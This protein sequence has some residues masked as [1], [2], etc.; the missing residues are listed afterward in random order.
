MTQCTIILPFFAN[1]QRKNGQKLTQANVSR[2]L[3]MTLSFDGSNNV[4]TITHKSWHLQRV[5]CQ[6]RVTPMKWFAL[7]L[8]S[9]RRPA[10]GAGSHL[11][12]VAS[13]DRRTDH[14]R[15]LLAYVSAEAHLRQSL[16]NDST[17]VVAKRSTRVALRASQVRVQRTFIYI[18]AVCVSFGSGSH[19][20]GSLYRPLVGPGS[21]VDRLCVCVFG[22]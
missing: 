6:W 15:A 3:K 21:A 11:P 18:Y 22:R 14:L 7:E 17:D 10:I 5:R 1:V 13:V 2:S 12:R 16:V 20:A 19:K 4:S 9:W 8:E